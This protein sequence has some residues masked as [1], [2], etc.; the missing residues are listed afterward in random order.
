M[1]AFQD[2]AE[3]SIYYTR[4]RFYPLP[5]YCTQGHSTRKSKYSCRDLK[6]LEKFTT[7]QD[8]VNQ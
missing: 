8:L 4:E 7:D 1:P 3:Y 2:I 6:N 5:M